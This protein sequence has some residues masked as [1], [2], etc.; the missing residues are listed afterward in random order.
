MFAALGDF[1]YR[2]RWLVVA[3]WLTG[4]VLAVPI[5]LRVEEPLKV[6]GFTSPGIESSRAS[7]A[8]QRHLTSSQSTVVVLFHADNLQASDRLFDAEVR[9]TLQPIEELAYV[10]SI[11]FP[12]DDEHLISDDGRTAYAIVGIDL[13][14][15]EAQQR[16]GAFKEALR[17]PPDLEVLVAGAPAFYAD[18]ETVSQS[19][20]RRAE[21]IALPV[22]LVALLLVFG[23]VVAAGVPLITGGLSVA[24]VLASL[25]ALAHVT[26]LSIFVMNLAT[27]LG[28]GLAVDYS[29]F[30]T[31]RFREELDRTDGQVHAAVVRTQATAGRAIFFSGFTVLIGLSGLV[32][33]DFMFLRSVGIAGV[34]VVTFAVGAALTLLPAVLG[35]VGTRID[36]LSLFSRRR[37][38]ETGE[39]RGFWYRLSHWV[40]KRPLLVAIP[41]ALLLISFGLPFRHVVISSPDATILP[42]GLPSRQAFDLM[43]EEFGAGEIS[44]FVVVLTSDSDMY[45]DGNLGAIFDLTAMLDQDPR[46]DHVQSI[47]PIAE[48]IGR[49]QAIEL[50]KLQPR[51]AELGLIDQSDRFISETAALIL[52]FGNDYAIADENKSL[53]SDIRG[54]QPPEGADV[55]LLAGGATAEIVD[56]VDKMYGQFPYAV[57]FVL[58][59]TYLVLLLLFRSLLLPLKAIILNTL[60]ILA[61]YGALVFIFQDGHLTRLL[62]FDPQGYV[63]ASLPIIMFCV[64]FGLSMDYEVFLLSRIREEWEQ[65]GDNTAAIAIGLQR[66]GRIIT[67]AALIVVVVTLSFAS[68]EVILIKALGVGI[69]IAV[70]LDATVIRAL[71]VPAMMR[72]MGDWNWWMPG[73][74]DRII[75]E[76]G[77]EGTAPDAIVQE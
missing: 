43:V 56:V 31:S 42:T 24:G 72:L 1:A 64:L 63:E 44:P 18:I 49:E 65:H 40:M 54:W 10:D 13:P 37:M 70:F 55:E 32:M 77:H 11:I 60:S 5:L 45:S 69:A 39:S 58:L 36:R 20:L 53:L 68:A 29:L 33:F 35:I 73:W 62:R 46:V 34:L 51:L 3:I 25:F 14:T 76:T 17:D 41:S 47:A 26:D 57:L 75:P 50:M 52:A 66:S 8:V 38:E 61:S 28:L 15:H 9:Y 74:L 12:S 7:A 30:I 59:V 16:M 22:A 67:S 4:F 71:L 21:L 48:G 23:S 6:G 27:M 2:R 19:D